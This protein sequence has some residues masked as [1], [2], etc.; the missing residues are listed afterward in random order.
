MRLTDA[1]V[2]IAALESGVTLLDTARAYGESEALVAAAVKAFAGQRPRIVTKG[3]MGA[4]WRPDGRGKTIAKDCATSRAVLGEIDLYLLHAPD[5]RVPLSTS[6]RALERLREEG[7]VR[8]IGLSNVSLPQLEEALALAPIAAVQLELGAFHHAPFRSGLVGFCVRHD[9]EVLAHTP[10]GGVKRAGGLEKNVALSRVA[11]RHEASAQRAV[12]SWLADLGIVALPGARRV[13]T[14]R[15]VMPFVLTDE[16]RAELDAE[17][18]AAARVF[19][20]RPSAA[21]TDGEVVLIIG[22]PG[23]GKSTE[24]A[25]WTA[26]GY[27]RLNRDERGGTLAALAKELDARLA[28]G[29]RRVVL[30][31]TYVTRASR[32]QVIEIAE[33]H[34][35][36]VRCVWM[37][38]PLEQAQIN[39][40]ERGRD[41]GMIPTSL[42]RVEREFEPPIASEGF[43]AI[44]RVPFVR[45]PRD[46]VPG[47]I[48][49]LDSAAAVRAWSA[50]ALVIAWQPR[51]KPALPEGVE[52]AVC[53]HE[54]GPPRC[55]CRPPLP[56]LALDWAK[57]RGVDL[58]KS[59][60][61]GKSP[62]AQKMAA[63]LGCAWSAE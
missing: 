21:K 43:A 7:Q 13:E 58:S 63:A 38:T 28:A 60:L 9:I 52:L 56:R 20:P 12:L 44:D 55:W 47:L 11:Q 31:N 53:E 42:L 18:T 35:L 3:G 1:A 32:N 30:D 39:V 34:G 14:A 37:D 45:A 17:F 50:P 4:Q 15:E 33:R 19:R 57:R 40:I 26:R 51:E 23:A 36:H 22:I 16:D 10:L 6:V 8:A 46:G 54:A 27:Q 62:A 48:V 41:D 29:A 61:V 2:I 24:V 25:K 5:P 59:R 49:F